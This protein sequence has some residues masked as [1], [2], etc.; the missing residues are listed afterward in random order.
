MG[1]KIKMSLIREI[2]KTY[3]L[4]LG[5]KVVC[6]DKHLK[7]FKSYLGK[8]DVCYTPICNHCPNL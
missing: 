6:I 8:Y 7:T 1:S 4:Q 3:C 2:L 5:Y